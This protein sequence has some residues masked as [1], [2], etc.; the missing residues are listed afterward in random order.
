LI[1]FFCLS[2]ECKDFFA[3]SLFVVGEFGGNDYNAP[4]FA[5][6]GLE[7]AYKFMPDVIQGISDGVEVA[8]CLLVQCNVD[9]RERY[10]YDHDCLCVLQALIAEGAVDLI[11]PGVMPTGCFPVYL[12][13][14]EEPTD[15]YGTR[16]GCVRRFNTF[17]W[18]HNSH[19]KAALEK[20]RAKHPNVRIMYGDYYTPVIQ[21]MLHPEKF[22]E[23]FNS[24]C[25]YPFFS[26]P[27][28]CLNVESTVNIESTISYCLKI[29]TYYNWIV[30]ISVDV[31]RSPIE[32]CNI[33]CEFKISLSSFVF[34]LF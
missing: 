22:G 9:C 5:G 21:F 18:V 17:S 27:H 14:L 31:T 10:G 24:R 12:N 16:T 33:K 2:T 25:C 26:F 32:H 20:L 6:Q 30:W 8:L 3:K 13:M 34:K 11:V 15:G 4:L 1:D 29:H 19:L 23:L 7:M 28:R